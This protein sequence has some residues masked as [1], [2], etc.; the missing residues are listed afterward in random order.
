MDYAKC[1]AAEKCLGITDNALESS[2]RPAT[3]MIVALRRACCRETS[4]RIKIRLYV[5]I[6]LYTII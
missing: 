6:Y 3:G 4:N 2:P 1:T 5:R